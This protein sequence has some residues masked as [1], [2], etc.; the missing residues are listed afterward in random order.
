CVFVL[1]AVAVGPLVAEHEHKTL[2]GSF[3]SLDGSVARRP[4]ACPWV[5]VLRKVV[6]GPETHT[7]VWGPRGRERGGVGHRGRR[8][9]VRAPRRT[10]RGAAGARCPTSGAVGRRAGWARASSTHRSRRAIK[11]RVARR[12][13]PHGGGFRPP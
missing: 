11:L 5:L 8:D 4:V 10:L 3:R 13:W 2:V 7:T 6:E 12:G 1:L 9:A